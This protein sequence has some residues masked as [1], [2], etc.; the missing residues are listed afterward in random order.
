MK[1]C[2]YIII[3]FNV[4]FPFLAYLKLIRDGSIISK[5]NYKEINKSE[6]RKMLITID[7]MI[8]TGFKVDP[9]RTSEFEIRELENQEMFVKIANKYSDIKS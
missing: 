9:I 8:K 3:F 5:H 6:N 4:F 7:E 2:L 1:I